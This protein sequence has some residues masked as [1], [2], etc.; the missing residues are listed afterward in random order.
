MTALRRFTSLALVT[1]LV[2]VGAAGVFA[3]QQ[4][5]ATPPSAEALLGQAL[6]QEQGQGR[7]EDAIATYRKVIAAHDA[8]RDQKARAQLRIGACYERL[9]MSEAKK[10]YEAALQY[11]D[12]PDVVRQARAR[13]AALAAPTSARA[14]GPVLRSLWKGVDVNTWGMVAPD[15]RTIAYVDWKLEAL[16]IRTVDTGEV[17]QIAVVQSPMPHTLSDRTSTS[18]RSIST[19]V[20]SWT[21]LATCPR[22][23][24]NVLPANMLGKAKAAAR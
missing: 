10:A 12:L 20:E 4:K 19:P 21:D 5:P 7:L 17:R 14:T 9:G 15:A 1:L 3:I 2:A 11:G 13:L 18:Q 16:M 6:H 23:L 8:T 24:E 22:L